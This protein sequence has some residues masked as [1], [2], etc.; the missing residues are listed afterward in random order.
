MNLVSQS[1]SYGN[2]RRLNINIDTIRRTKGTPP[3]RINIPG[4]S[5]ENQQSIPIQGQQDSFDVIIRVK[6]ESSNVGFDVNTSGTTS[7]RSITSIVDQYNFLYDE[8]ITND[9]AANYELYIEWANITFRGSLL[10]NDQAFTGKDFGQEIL[11]TLTIGRGKN[12]I[13]TA[14]TGSS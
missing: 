10:V 11:I 3:N 13:F 8:I 5:A 7:S 2:G 1:R 6:T 9:I 14:L 4:V 12:F